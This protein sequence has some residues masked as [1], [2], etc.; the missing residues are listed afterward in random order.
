MAAERGANIKFCLK[1]GKTAA[2][3]YEIMK[4]VYGVI[5]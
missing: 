4:S 5:V 2:E 1:L 3:A